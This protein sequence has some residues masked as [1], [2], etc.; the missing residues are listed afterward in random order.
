MSIRSPGAQLVR[1]LLDF[2]KLAI[3]DL[4][5]PFIYFKR[6][7]RLS[8]VV[9]ASFRVQQFDVGNPLPAEVTNTVGSEVK[10]G[11]WLVSKHIPKATPEELELMTADDGTG[12]AVRLAAM[13]LELRI[14]SHTPIRKHANIVH[15]ISFS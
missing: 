12:D 11:R 9:S 10:R 1:G 8:A 3:Q 4:N 14:L 5:V 2:I 7:L 15:L 13:S 6:S